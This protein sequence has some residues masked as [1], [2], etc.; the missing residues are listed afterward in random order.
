MARGFSLRPLTRRFVT[1]TVTTMRPRR[2]PRSHPASPLTL[3]GVYTATI[4]GGASGVK[5]LFGNALRRTSPVVHD[6]ERGTPPAVVD[7]IADG[8]CRQ[9]REYRADYRY[10]R[11]GERSRDAHVRAPQSGRRAGGDDAHLRCAVTHG[12]AVPTSPLAANTAFTAALERVTDAY[13]NAMTPATWSFTTGSYG[14]VESVVFS[15]LIEPTAMQFAPD[16]RV[17]VAEKRGVIKVFDSLTDQTPTVF[18]DLRTKVH[19]YW[20]RGMLGLALHPSFPTQPYV[21][22]LYTYDAAIGA[23]APRWGQADVDSDDCPSPPGPNGDGCVVSARLSRLTASGNVMTGT[24]QVLIESWGQQ[25]PSHSIGTLAFG[26][27]GALYVSGGDGA[28]FTF[29]D[30]GQD[31]N[32][33]NPLGDAPVPVGGVQSPPTLREAPSGAR[34]SVRRQTRRG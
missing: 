28:S 31:G 18:A 33:V 9:R 12:E 27:D 16:G 23:V 13:G 2:R 21:Y 22:V 8:C 1:A 32:P 17:F 7:P 4:T 19:N 5:D 34:I 14:F 24:E 25:Y 29:V 10:L 11:R 30:Y 26:P 3:G 15:G 20:D 6:R